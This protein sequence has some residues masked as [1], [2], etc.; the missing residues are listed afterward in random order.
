MEAK[1]TQ[2]SLILVIF[3]TRCELLL[4]VTSA[5]TN[6]LGNA[7]TVSSL[8]LKGIPG[9]MEQAVPVTVKEWQQLQE[10]AISVEW[11]YTGKVS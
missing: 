1:Q 7:Q 8:Q 9:C 10:S 5:Q 11:T 2:T 6:A 4:D 3:L